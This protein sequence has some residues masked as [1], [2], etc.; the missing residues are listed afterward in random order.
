[1]QYSDEILSEM[2]S[3]A[4]EAINENELCTYCCHYNSG[5]CR[6]ND[7]ICKNGIWRGLQLMAIER[8]RKV[9]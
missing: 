7:D 3:V 1:M 4:V 6:K 5:N 2:L 9:S 8:V